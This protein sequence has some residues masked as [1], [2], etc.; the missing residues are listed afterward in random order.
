MKSIKGAVEKG[1]KNIRIALKGTIT[2]IIKSNKTIYL[3]LS[4]EEEL[5]DVKVISHYGFYSLP[6]QGQMGQ[7][8]FNNTAKKASFIGIEHENIPIDI[9]P[10]ETLIYCNSG[11]HILLKDGKVFIK[12]DLNVTGNIIASGIVDGSNI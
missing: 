2:S 5:R 1:L 7:I 8:L 9:N 12:G 6:L 10:G 4:D 11:S 3:K